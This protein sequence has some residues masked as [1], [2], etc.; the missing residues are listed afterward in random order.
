[1][2]IITKLTDYRFLNLKQVVDPEFNVK[3]YQF[4]E[5]LGKDSI[6]FVCY[7]KN[8]H[9]ILLNEEFKPPIGKFVVTAFGG[10]LDKEKDVKTIVQDEV[11]EEAG[12]DV[13]IKDII[14]VG[15]VFVSTQMN[16]WCRLYLVY[17]NKGMQKERQPENDV[18]K[19]ARLQWYNINDEGFYI[20]SPDWKA[21]TILS[22]AE[23][24][25]IL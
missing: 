10:S 4:A 14:E 18:E 20:N 7:D 2:R 25:R 13:E 23:R 22:K 19:I 9:Q 24:M 3:N 6:A 12:F 16:Q 1:M 17:V 8:R 11:R 21:L 15:S 5:R